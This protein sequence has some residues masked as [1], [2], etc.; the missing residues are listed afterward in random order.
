M[1]ALRDRRFLVETATGTQ[2]DLAVPTPSI[3]APIGDRTLATRRPAYLKPSP[4]TKNRPRKGPVL[5]RGRRQIAPP[6]GR[7]QSAPYWG[8][9][10]FDTLEHKLPPK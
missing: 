2:V 5:I 6:A 10:R 4:Q 8:H 1:T 3:A 9:E 7:A